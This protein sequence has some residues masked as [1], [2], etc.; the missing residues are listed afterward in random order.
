MTDDREYQHGTPEAG[1]KRIDHGGI[2][3]KAEASGDLNGNEKEAEKVWGE[4]QPNEFK[5]NEW[6]ESPEIVRDASDIAGG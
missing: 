1:Q 4:A 5:R 6:G 2:K 3:R